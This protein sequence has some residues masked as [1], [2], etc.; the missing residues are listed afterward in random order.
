MRLLERYKQP[1]KDGRL[2]PRETF[3]LALPVPAA[4]L[5]HVL[6][7]NVYIKL[8]TDLIGLHPMYVGLVY[9]IYN[10]WNFLNDPLIGIL[11]DRKRVDPQ[12]GKFLHIMRVSVPFMLLCLV[13]MLLSQPTW[14]QGLIFTALLV[15]LFIFDTFAT[16]YGVATNSFI[17]VAASSKEERVN[18]NVVQSYVANIVSFFATL[19][20]TFLL[21]GNKEGDRGMIVLI[22]LGVVALNA[23]IYY[24]ALKNLEDRPEYYAHGNIEESF[25][26]ATLWADVRALFGS[27]TFRAWAGYNLLALAPNAVYFTAFL[28]LM[29]HVIRTG[30]LEATLADTVPMLVVFAFLP[31]IAKFIKK[32]GG[33]KSIFIGSVPYIIGHVWL[34]FTGSWLA[35]LLAYIPIMMGKYM[36][37]TAGAPL[38]AALVD[39]N[40]QLTGTRKPGLI[41]ALMALIA[42]P[43]LSSQLVLFMG[44]LTA[45]GYDNKA[46]VQT[47]QAMLGI[48]VGTALVPIAFV[49]VGLIPLLRFPINQAREEELSRFSQERRRGTLPEETQEE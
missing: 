6:I 47:E 14:P 19:V 8:Y 13:A 5:S 36:M 41:G 20:P 10:I 28:Y 34:F 37:S 1:G 12:R 38:Y 25:N 2:S 7:H 39:E 16:A 27:R 15:A 35:V 9:L 11:I 48:R 32:N 21:V 17:M 18:V 44:I 42:A 33:K 40:E 29:D 23:A 26:L 31:L 3:L 30:G 4:S 49:L 45:F 43:A 24:V 22:L 46:A